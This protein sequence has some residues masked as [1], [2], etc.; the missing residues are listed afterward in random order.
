MDKRNSLICPKC[1]DVFF[2]L[3]DALKH[4]SC[5]VMLNWHY[6]DVIPKKEKNKNNAKKMLFV[7]DRTKRIHY[8]LNNFPEY[9]VTIA[10]CVPE[11]L[12]ALSSQYWDVVSLDHDLNGHD[13]QSPL[14]ETCGMEIV[15]YI[16]KC[17]WPDEWRKRPTFHIHSSNLFAA[18]L[19]I[20]ALKMAGHEAWYKPII[21]P[22]ENMEYDEKGI[23]VS[24][25]DK[26]SKFNITEFFSPQPEDKKC[27]RCGEFRGVNLDNICLSCWDGMK[28][29]RL[30]NP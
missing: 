13:F 6:E 11:A 2:F 15:R 27:W 4:N 23:P 17:G 1:E 30:S 14:T 19:M 24:Q 21:Y 25:K 18:H 16:A 12:R 10:T 26:E 28:T 8:A 29:G 9:D 5:G 20:T 22:V 7:D 3:D